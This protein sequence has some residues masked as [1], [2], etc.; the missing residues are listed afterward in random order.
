MKPIGSFLL[1]GAIAVAVMW[2]IHLPGLTSLA[3]PV[4]SATPVSSPDAAANSHWLTPDWSDA[5]AEAERHFRGLDVAMMEIGH[6]FEELQLAGAERNWPLAR[7]QVEKIELALNLA[8][9]RRPKR[10]ASAAPFLQETIPFVRSA[11][12]AAE[13]AEGTRPFAEI[14]E[15]MRT[16]CMKCHVAE[17]VP[18]FTVRIGS[19]LDSDNNPMPVP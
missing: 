13:N 3:Q 17:N 14:I 15:R 19:S 12:A 11:I 10:A 7:Y 16:D 6:R 2:Q 8:L 9:E 5:R 18:H 1:G 4:T